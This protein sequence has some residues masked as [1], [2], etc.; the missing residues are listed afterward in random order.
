MNNKGLFQRLVL[1]TV[2][3]IGFL[4]AWGMAGIWGLEVYRGIVLV[5]GDLIIVGHE[6]SEEMAFRSDGTP[7][8]VRGNGLGHRQYRDLEGVAVAPPSVGDSSAWINGTQLPASLP[9]GRGSFDVSWEDR[10]RS[11]GDG[12][13]PPVRWHFVSDGRPEGGAYF[14]GY[15]SQSKMCVG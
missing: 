10:I 15:D 13:T 1:A 12:R 14:V 9:L 3:A 7:L 11:F 2:L 6:E 8:I 4:C 5:H